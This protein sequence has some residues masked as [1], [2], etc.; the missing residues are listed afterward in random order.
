MVSLAE[1]AEV[2]AALYQQGQ[3]YKRRSREVGPVRPGSRFGKDILIV[4]ALVYVTDSARM[5]RVIAERA[6]RA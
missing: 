6:R 1:L 5:A 4:Y 2:Q 3:D